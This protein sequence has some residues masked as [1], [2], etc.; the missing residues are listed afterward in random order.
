[1]AL[2]RQGPNLNVDHTEVT[3]TPNACPETKLQY[4]V[5]TGS[6]LVPMH[7]EVISIALIDC[8]WWVCSGRP[9][10]IL[11]RSTAQTPPT[12]KSST[13]WK[14]WHGKS[15]CDV[16]V[17]IYPPGFFQQITKALMHGTNDTWW[18]LWQGFFVALWCSMYNPLAVSDSPQRWS[19]LFCGCLPCWLLSTQRHCFGQ[20]TAFGHG[21]SLPSLGQATVAAKQGSHHQAAQKS[22]TTQ[23]TAARWPGTC[24]AAKDSKRKE[25]AGEAASVL[26][27]IEKLNCTHLA[28]VTSDFPKCSCH[29]M[30]AS[31]PEQ[32]EQCVP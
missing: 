24:A 30:A 18:Y 21:W 20:R 27:G 32:F 8:D 22:A 25:L 2:E 31:C 10:P 11:E 15:H 19:R 23:G 26:P 12:H 4:S 16:L 9:L 6:S 17:K 1:M 3:L 5:K 7:I 13:N 29:K 14:P 28:A